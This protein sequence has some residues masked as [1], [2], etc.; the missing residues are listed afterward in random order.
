MNYIKGDLIE[1]AKD[2][3]FDVIVHG[4][5]SFNSFAAGIAATIRKEFPEAYLAD[6]KTIKGDKKKI[7]TYTQATVNIKGQPLTIVN[8]YTQY[9]FWG[10]KDVDLVE[11]EGLEKILNRLKEEFKGK[12]IGFPLIGCGLANG[13]KNRIVD[14]ITTQ[15]EGCD[16]TIVEWTKNYIPLYKKMK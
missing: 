14:M 1:M 4:C 15:L 9:Q 10:D 8:A 16:V 12:S 5:N 7:G 2:G 6:Q 3:E 13:D 11:Y